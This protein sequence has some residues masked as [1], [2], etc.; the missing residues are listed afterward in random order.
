MKSKAAVL[1]MAVAMVLAVANVGLAAK[2]IFQDNFATFGPAWGS[3]NAI[4]NVKDGK[5]VVTPKVKTT[6]TMINEGQ[7]LPDNADITFN[8]TFLK[9]PAPSWGSGLVF[10]AKD[11]SDYYALL[12]NANGWFAVQH[13]VANRYLLPVAWRKTTIIKKGAGAVHQVMVATKGNKATISVDGKELIT[14]S[15]QPPKGGSLV[16][17][18]VASGNKAANSVAFGDLKVTQP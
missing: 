8:M 1:V 6:H 3:P 10:W 9:A 2:V 5:L 12:I 16:G 11:Y 7:L 17:F 13:H 15:G 14:L 4:Q 18:K